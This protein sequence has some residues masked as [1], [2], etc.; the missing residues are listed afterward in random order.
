[1]SCWWRAGLVAAAVGASASC[2]A[3][4]QGGDPL[5]GELARLEASAAQLAGRTPQGLSDALGRGREG[6]AAVRA[7]RDPHLALYRLREPFVTLETVAYVVEHGDAGADL[8]RLEAAWKGEGVAAAPSAPATASTLHLALW[9]AEANKAEKLYAAALPYGRAAG[10]PAGL[11]YLGEALAYRRFR[12]LVARAAP[13]A[14]PR[15]AAEPAVDAAALE[16]A[17]I[18]L[19]E[20]TVAAFSRDP[21][22]PTM[23][24]VSARLKEAR[25]LLEAN[26][27][28]GAALTTLE[29]RLALSRRLRDP[30][31]FGAPAAPGSDA[32]RAAGAAE[33]TAAPRRGSDGGSSLRALY[34]AAAAE[35]DAPGTASLVRDDVL[36]L[37]DRLLR[38]RP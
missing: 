26:A 20:A 10:P 11:Y 1:M 31:A 36:P 13:P 23:V 17:L 30:A 16:G 4:A 5:A 27:L 12:D 9:Q 15:A 32:P 25:E 28:A 21:A 18:E 22:A 33:P 19:E 24:A 2:A 14:E 29:A 34:L 3:G 35:D 6:L 8:A 37:H 38:S 7:A